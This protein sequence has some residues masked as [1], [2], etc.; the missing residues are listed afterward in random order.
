MKLSINIDHV[1][2]LREA[3]GGL[4][5]D[6]VTAAHLCEIA[7][8]HGI[9]CHLREDRRHINDRDLR[10]L[11]DTVKTRLDLEMA[12]T[13]EI[14]AVAIDTLP[15]LATLVPERRQELTT[16]GGLDVRGNRHRLRDVV[17]R[18]QDHEIQVSL[19]VDPLPEQIE[20]AREIG[21]DKI[22]IHTGAYANARTEDQQRELLDV[23]RVSARMAR[24]LGLGVNAGHGLNYLN[25]IPFRATGEID[26][27]SIGH[28]VIARA[29]F[30][31][32]D[33]AVKEMLALV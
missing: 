6:P 26:E 5:P 1:A 19:F 8:A 25:V 22:E 30:V 15:E 23:V 13:D 31:G 29:L 24:E 33:R 16:E 27:V 18:L 21:A 7:G 9:V 3:R 20:S 32:I 2:T 14:V 4:E 28:A 12:A 10:L 17:A 11:R